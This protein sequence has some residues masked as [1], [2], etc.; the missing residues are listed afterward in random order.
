MHTITEELVAA[1]RARIAAEASAWGVLDRV[2]F[3]RDMLGQRNTAYLGMRDSSKSKA[4]VLLMEFDILFACL[5]QVTTRE[6]FTRISRCHPKC[7]ETDIGKCV[8][9]R[10]GEGQR[11]VREF[12]EMARAQWGHVLSWLEEPV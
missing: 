7:L 2:A 5:A 10:P 9:K 1:H 11:A 8:Q 4:V 12:R 6:M 3:L